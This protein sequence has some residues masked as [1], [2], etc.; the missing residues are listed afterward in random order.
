[1][2]IEMNQLSKAIILATKAHAGQLDKAGEQYILHPLRL[3]IKAKN[4]IDRCVAVLHDVVE[5]T[6]INIHDLRREGFSEEIIEAVLCLTKQKGESYKE[7]IIRLSKNKVARRV[8]ILD[9][10]DNLD[11]SRLKDITDKDIKRADK[12]K[13]ALALLEEV[14]D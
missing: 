12:Y 3:M 5:D 4:E 13:K 7:F 8:K 2:D 14:T 9:L 6:C 10:K 11:L 1:M